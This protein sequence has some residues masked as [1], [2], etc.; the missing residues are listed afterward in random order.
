MSPVRFGLIFLLGV[1]CGG[2]KATTPVTDDD[3]VVAYDVCNNAC[4]PIC[5]AEGTED[6]GCAASCPAQDDPPGNCI[7]VGAGTCGWDSE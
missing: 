2:S 5:I 4:T 7:L 3:C 6:T 1:G